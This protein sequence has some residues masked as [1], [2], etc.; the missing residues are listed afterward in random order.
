MILPPLP[1]DPSSVR[2]YAVDLRSR[3][4]RYSA[5][6]RVI[7]RL[8]GTG[9]WDGPTGAAF[10]EQLARFPA[11][12][13][14]VIHR[15]LAAAAALDL[16]AAALEAEQ[17]RVQWAIGEDQDAA[18]GEIACE[19][20]LESL[21]ASGEMWESPVV[22][23]VL[24]RQRACTA[25]RQ[26]A[27][28][29]HRTAWSRFNEADER[30]ASALRA[31][32]QD[33]LVDTA[34]YRSVRA[35]QEIGD[36]LASIGLLAR[37]HPALAGLALVGT[38][39]GTLADVTMLLAYDEGSWGELATEFGLGAL[40]GG[41]TVL[42]SASTAGG[43][44]V[45]GGVI[46]DRTLTRGDRLRHGASE[47]IEGWSKDLDGLAPLARANSRRPPA[48][49]PVPAAVPAG[50]R[51]RINLRAMLDKARDTAYRND[52]RLA[53]AAGTQARTM[54]LTSVGLKVGGAATN[55]A[56]T[57]RERQQQR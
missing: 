25:R 32:A 50:T 29:I 8:R 36:G 4:A 18:A 33:R 27:Q 49:S 20:E 11:H 45:N 21:M 7:G 55:G 48:L 56:L 14:L 34:V 47:L 39:G 44:I 16:L 1:G 42:K 22:Q 35:V 51:A 40:G 54:Y 43:K 24:A 5:T 6:A 26:D 10:A 46:A 30:C 57:L 3:A 28:A 17:P 19:R 23:G 2:S 15:Y 13:D 53:T 52:L 41:A 9:G 31:A 37:A 12:L 38:V